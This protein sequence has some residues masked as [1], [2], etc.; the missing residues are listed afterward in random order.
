VRPGA[1]RRPYRDLV[2]HVTPAL[3]GIRA[4]ASPCACR[5]RASGGVETVGG[6]DVGPALAKDQNQRSG[7]PLGSPPLSRATSGAARLLAPTPVR[8]SE[9]LRSS[10]PRFTRAVGPRNMRCFSDG[11]PAGT[12]KSGRAESLD[13]PRRAQRQQLAGRH[14]WVIR[15]RS[16]RRIQPH[17]I[18][19]LLPGRL[20]R[21][22]AQAHRRLSL[23][24]A[25]ILRRSQ[26]SDTDLVNEPRRQ[27][28]AVP[29]HERQIAGLQRRMEARE[30]NMTGKKPDTNVCSHR[31]RRRVTGLRACASIPPPDRLSRSR[32]ISSGWSHAPALPRL[33]PGQQPSASA[34]ATP[35]RRP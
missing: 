6:G 20:L 9:R 15:Y 35:G 8:A 13:R 34:A 21:K 18:L 17:V 28:R 14:L 11:G 19:E 30:R 16:K 23:K 27:A 3:G 5:I 4:R 31:C 32:P 7:W 24:P 25:R 1:S 10:L 26:L 33:P 2:V 12:R 29:A 22:P